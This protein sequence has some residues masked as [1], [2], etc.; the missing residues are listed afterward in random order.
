MR[1]VLSFFIGAAV[2]GMVGASTALLLTTESGE[3]LRS[4]IRDRAQGF[5][6]DVRQAASSR[7]IEL[8]ERLETLRTPRA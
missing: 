6:A 3:E 5:A 4:H 2:G 7:R 1:R 8:Q